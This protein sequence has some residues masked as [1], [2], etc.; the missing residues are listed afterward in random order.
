MASNTTQA[1]AAHQNTDALLALAQHSIAKDKR[2]WT[3]E[4]HTPKRRLASRG[5]H[6]ECKR[7][8]HVMT[9]DIHWA[10]QS[11]PLN[12]C[13][14]RNHR[15]INPEQSCL[16]L[17]TDSS[18]PNDQIAV[19]NL[20]HLERHLCRAEALHKIKCTMK[21]IARDDP[22]D[23]RRESARVL[24]EMMSAVPDLLTPSPNN[25]DSKCEVSCTYD[26][27]PSTHRTTMLHAE[28]ATSQQ[29]HCPLS[30]SHAQ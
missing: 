5:D 9:S 15:Q 21:V 7:R 25:V 19:T 23:A 28:Q 18:D 13:E 6:G 17:Q 20:T 3:H 22:S 2:A 27:L 14:P 24:L 30:P 12:D 4:H 16:A 26:S 10:D 11:R 1:T 8:R 29:T